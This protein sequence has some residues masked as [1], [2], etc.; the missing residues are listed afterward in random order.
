MNHLLAACVNGEAHSMSCH[1]H[2][3][4]VWVK[5]VLDSLTKLL[6]KHLNDS[7]DGIAPELCGSLGFTSLARVFDKMFSLYANYPNGIGEVFRQWTKANHA[8]ELLFHAERACSGGRQD[9]ASIAAM[10]I[11]WNKNYCVE[12]LDDMISYCGKS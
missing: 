2:L 8:G 3:R 7:L 1:N 12:F 5:N 10:A 6:R 4:N 9:I 11:F